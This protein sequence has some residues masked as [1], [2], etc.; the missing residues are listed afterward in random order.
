MNIKQKNNG[1]TLIALVVTIIVLLILAGITINLAFNSN[2]ILN[3]A[4]QAKDAQTIGSEKELI[5]LEQISYETGRVTDTLKNGIEDFKAGIHKAGVTNSADAPDITGPDETGSI[6]IVSK[7]GNVYEVKIDPATKKMQTGVDFLDPNVPRVSIGVTASTISVT[8]VNPQVPPYTCEIKEVEAMGAGTKYEADQSKPNF[9]KATGL[10]K[11]TN[12]EVKV[13]AGGL[14]E[15]Y[16]KQ[17]RTVEIVEPILSAPQ[18]LTWNESGQASCTLTVSNVKPYEVIKWKKSTDPEGSWNSLTPGQ[19]KITI[20]NVPNGTIIIVEKTDG[21]QVGAT[22]QQTIEDVT[23]PA[24]PTFSVTKGTLG[25]DGKTYIKDASGSSD[26]IVRITAGADKESGANKI[27]YSVEGAT[28]VTETTTNAATLTQD[29]TITANGTSTIT[30]Y[31]ID[32]AGKVSEAAKKV[33]IINKTGTVV[34]VES[35]KSFSANKAFTISATTDANFGKCLWKVDN[36]SA[37]LGLIPGSYTG[38]T[39]TGT[40]GNPINI[41]VPASA[42]PTKGTYYIH[43]LAVDKVG[44]MSQKTTSI[45]ITEELLEIKN[46]NRDNFGQY[47]GMKVDYHPQTPHSDYGTSTTYR[48]FYVDYDNKYGDGPGTIYLKADSDYAAGKYQRFDQING[49]RNVTNYQ[50]A[51][52]ST[53][54]MAKHNPLWA[55]SGDNTGINKSCVSFMMDESQWTDWI[56]NSTSGIS[57]KVNYVVGGPSLEMFV[58]SYNAMHKGDTSGSGATNFCYKYDGAP[59]YKVGINNNDYSNGNG[60]YTASGTLKPDI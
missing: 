20:T 41:N 52:N 43:I 6:T 15:P 45:T 58:D 31:T 29:I 5:S 40:A 35:G 12:Y 4:S 14:A 17:V 42:I 53:S 56:D 9:F 38:G 46:M 10:K 44:N 13:T 49:S 37:E 11:N 8:V 21:E 27:K 33:I 19:G 22:A 34:T 18:N 59:G 7:S 25:T 24:V 3:R 32:K 36:S 54:R 39:V 30:A 2:G 16:V 50:I 26:V 55:K 57:G 23:P 60:N 51:D 47:L 48:I 1:I 28:T